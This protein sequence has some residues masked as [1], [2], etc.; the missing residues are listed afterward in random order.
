MTTIEAFSALMPGATGSETTTT[1]TT[2]AAGRVGGDGGHVLNAANAHARAGKRTESALST[3]AGGLCTSSTSGTELDVEGGDAN[4][5]AAR[6]DVLG[7]QHGRVGR[8]LVTVCLDLHTTSD[9]RD[10]LLARQIRDMDEGVVERGVDVGN[11]E[12]QL[13]LRNLGAERDGVLILRRLGLLGV[14]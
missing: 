4:L 6:S 5:T 1:A 14:L 9:T 7:S 2:L 8:G 3:G 11:P 10:G 12:D 13:S